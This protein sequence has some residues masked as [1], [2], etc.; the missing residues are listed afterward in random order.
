MFWGVRLCESSHFEGLQC[1]HDSLSHFEDFEP[2]D[3]FIL[4][5]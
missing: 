1:P 2:S 4:L 3:S 5:P